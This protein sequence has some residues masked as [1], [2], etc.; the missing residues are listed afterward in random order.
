MK[1]QILSHAGL[2]IESQ[3]TVLITDPWI[4]GSAYWRSWWNYP[5]VS[6]D[7]VDSLRPNYIYLTHI[8]WDH[9]HGPSLRKLGKNTHII[10]PETPG[11]RMRRDLEQMGFHNIT[12]LR[13]S[14]SLQL[15]NDFKITSYHFSPFLDS[16]L[17]IETEGM[18]LLNSNDAKLMGLPFRQLLKN[19]PKIDFVFRSHSS[20]NSR[21]CY[22]FIDSPTMTYDDTTRYAK[23]F[24]HFCI[25]TKAKY[26]IPFA[27]N[28][29]HLH[30]DVFHFNELVVTPFQVKQYF[31]DNHITQ[32]EIKLM[33]SGDTWS[34]EEGFI[35]SDNTYFS[36]R[37]HHLKLY[38]E[39]NQHI[40]DQFYQREDEASIDLK[41][42]NRYF[43][44]FFAS[45]PFIIRRFFKNHPIY[46]ILHNARGKRYFC[47]N[48]YRKE[49]SE[50]DHIDN[51]AQSIQMLVP[52]FVMRHCLI[53]SLFSHLPISKRIKYRMHTKD[54][55]FVL[56]YNMLI[57][58]YEYELVPLKNLF[59]KRMFRIALFR[60]REGFLYLSIIMKLM[61]GKKMV[62][63]HYLPKV[64]TSKR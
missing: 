28:H 39:N 10:I 19:H 47:V 1:F 37:A 15:A 14:E 41:T 56:I 20:A 50:L 32:P 58:L 52:T 38:Q 17:V 18:T 24:A 36:D 30:K 26:A 9:Y 62:Q 29:C 49:V 61:I 44:P 53:A 43:K 59:S 51:Q 12:E 5:P 63:G 31:A 55:K 4:I 2:L 27:S 33:L 40:L 21:L 7:L 11:L 6:Q 34:S 25:A 35:I 22:E 3:G 60:W 13:H 16:V 54:K 45:L 57:N 64:R 23:D 46:Y 8:H 42:M 48:I